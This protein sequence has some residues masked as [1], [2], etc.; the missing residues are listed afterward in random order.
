VD[1]LTYIFAA[2]VLVAALLGAIAIR[3]P[4]A[5]ALRAGAVVLAGALMATGYAGFAE[6]MGRPKPASLEWAARNASE[7]TVLAADMRE[8]EAIYLWLRLDETPEPR[9]YVLPWSL[10]AA[11]QLYRA[12]GEAEESGTAVRMRGPFIDADEGGERM[13]YAE[14]QPPLPAKLVRAQ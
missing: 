14:P 2:T 6:L 3:A 4:R 8:G 9:A 13:F 12:Q 7:A 5:L 11:R 1:S 10:A